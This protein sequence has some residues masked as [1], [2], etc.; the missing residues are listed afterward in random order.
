MKRSILTIQ[1]LFVAVTLIAQQKN[2]LIIS[3]NVDSVGNN[4]SGT[5]LPEIAYPFKTFTD[6]GYDVDIVTPL[7]GKA[8][9]YEAK[10]PAE[11][12][13]IR[14]SKTFID[15]VSNTLSPTQV[16]PKKY[17]A[18]YVPG[19][20]GQ[21]FDVAADERIANIIA[22]VYESGGVVGTAGHGTASLVNVRL[23]NCSFLVAGKSM[24]TF[25]SWAELKWMNISNYGKLLPFVMADVIKR[26]GAMLIV[27]PTI[28][29]N[30]NFDFTHVVDRQNRFVT[31]SYANSAGWVA[32]EMIKI[33]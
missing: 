12:A 20:H 24:T 2:I 21:F 4:R 31:G 3:T 5:Y 14:D 15:K 29:S 26:R 1:F 9:I 32:E 6:K 11:L 33:F 22:S 19:G 23:S 13:Q 8:A 28:E 16:D 17:R 27:P 18:V 7:G 25:P 30:E 10:V